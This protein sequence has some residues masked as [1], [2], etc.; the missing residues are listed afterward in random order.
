MRLF[1]KSGLYA[2]IKNSSIHFPDNSHLVGDLAYKLSPYLL[3]GFK[4]VGGLNNREKNF[5]KK[6]SQC[7]VVIENTYAY[8]KKR[9]RRLKYLE[10]VRLDLICLLTVSACIMHNVCILNGDV[11]EELVDDMEM[12][13]ARENDEF[14]ADM[15][16]KQEN[17]DKGVLKSIEIMNIFPMGNV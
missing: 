5:N 9:F 14:I 7:R 8:L 3:V 4:D 13:D 2:R 15:N 17:N 12:R 1:K 16:E 6:L 10:T 11:P